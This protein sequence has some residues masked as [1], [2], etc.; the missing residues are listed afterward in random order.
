[1]RFHLT[2]A[3]L[4]FFLCAGPVLAEPQ[5]VLFTA[6]DAV[7]CLSPDNLDVANQPA[8]ANSETV[9]RSMGCLRTGS[10]VRTR[11]M[12]STA[13]PA[14][15][16]LRVRFYPAGISGG[17]MLWALPSAFTSPIG[18]HIPLPKRG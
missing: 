18:T 13:V 14:G 9:L 16:P 8:V 10:G 15:N 6:P 2:A 11:L 5:D 17:I 12:D 1:M 7:L 3:V 4:S